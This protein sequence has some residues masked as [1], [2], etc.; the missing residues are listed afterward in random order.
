MSD[1]RFEYIFRR[2]LESKTEM[3]PGQIRDITMNAM[4]C[5]QQSRMCTCDK[6]MG[7]KD[8]GQADSN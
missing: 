5:L 1:E 3:T 4:R 6:C 7:R 8:H 2:W